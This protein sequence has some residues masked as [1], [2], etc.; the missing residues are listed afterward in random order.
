MPIT[1]VFTGIFALF[2]VFLIL[3][4]ISFRQKNN[5]PYGDGNNIEM[6]RRQRAQGNFAEYVPLAL[7]MLGL[8]E[9][10]DLPKFI[11]LIMAFVLLIGRISHAY[12]LLIA[13]GKGIQN[14]KNLFPRIAGMMLTIS[15]FMVSALICI[16]IGIIKIF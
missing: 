7:F 13:E 16:T 2:Y 5:L 14:R 11:I 12:G 10:A 6:I 4:V 8:M 1:L 9:I 15:Y 3:N